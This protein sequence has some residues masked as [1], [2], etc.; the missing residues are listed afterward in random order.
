MTMILDQGISSLSEYVHAKQR[1]QKAEQSQALEKRKHR[2]LVPQR[3]ERCPECQEA[4]CFW[5]KGYYFRWAVEKGLAEVIAVPRYICRCCKLVV[6]ILFA[7]L[8]PC[9]QLTLQA[10]SEGIQ[11]YLDKTTTYE[12]TA[13]EIAR[14]AEMQRPAS[15]QVYRWVRLFAVIA[16][17]NLAVRLQRRCLAA[18][19]GQQLNGLSQAECPNSCKAKSLNKIAALNRGK[20]VLGLARVFLQN[21][22]NV[23]CA[24]Q[25]YFS[26]FVKSP[27]SILTGRAI[28]LLTPQRLEHAM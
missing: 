1:M 13:A 4:G 16:G 26:F 22:S 28:K 27:W 18:G 7:F 25:T 5:T 12:E 14:D 17:N 19:K 21:E 11:D 20:Q 15:S 10:M 2:Y 6:S 9:R 3:P 23:V 8:V 24:L